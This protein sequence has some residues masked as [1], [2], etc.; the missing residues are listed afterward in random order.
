MIRE[1]TRNCKYPSLSALYK[2]KYK[3]IKMATKLYKIVHT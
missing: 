3:K 2:Y 1:K